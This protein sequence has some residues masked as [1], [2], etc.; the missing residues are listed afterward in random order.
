MMYPVYHFLTPIKQAALEPHPLVTLDQFK[1]ISDK[2]IEFCVAVNVTSPF[3]WMEYDPSEGGYGDGGSGDGS[4]H[5]RRRKDR[6]DGDKKNV[7]DNGDVSVHRRRKGGGEGGKN[8]GDGD[9]GDSGSSSSSRGR[10]SDYGDKNKSPARSEGSQ[11]D[12][13]KRYANIHNVNAGW[14]NDNNFLAEAGMSY[15]I[16]YTSYDHVLPGDVEMFKKALNVR[17]LQQI[18]TCD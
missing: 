14:F 17:V 11:S 5:S 13:K 15:T 4:M 9:I 10:D 12:S 3:L 8:D 7:D 6:G 16:R 18:G 2:I 1:I